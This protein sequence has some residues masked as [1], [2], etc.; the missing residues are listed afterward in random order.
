MLFQ[1]PLLN[2]NIPLIQI[3]VFD[4]LS[5]WEM[6]PVVIRYVSD[7]LTCVL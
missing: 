7:P 6:I 4:R 5:F 2:H 3:V 1:Y